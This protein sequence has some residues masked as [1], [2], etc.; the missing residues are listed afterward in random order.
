MEVSSSWVVVCK[1][2]VLGLLFVSYQFLGCCME[3]SSS[4]VVVCKLAVLGLLFFVSLNLTA[5]T[6]LV[7][8]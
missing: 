8:A 7:Q 3:V 6:I 1:L 5:V 2:A 4:W